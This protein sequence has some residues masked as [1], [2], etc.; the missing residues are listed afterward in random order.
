VAEFLIDKYKKNSVLSGK[1]SQ[2]SGTIDHSNYVEM[3]RNS[4]NAK[5]I[6][7][8]VNSAAKT[9]SPADSYYSTK[10]FGS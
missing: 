6:S 2:F 10:G 5:K 7:S 3:M 4:V 1:G 9:K 8:S